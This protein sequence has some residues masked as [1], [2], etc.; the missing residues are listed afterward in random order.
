MGVDRA[1]QQ[2]VVLMS[3]ERITILETRMDSATATI[4]QQSL[5]I[6][7]LTNRIMM[8]EAESV[9]DD[10]VHKLARNIGDGFNNIARLLEV[11]E[12]ELYDSKWKRRENVS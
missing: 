3:D 2:G 6:A 8:L 12:S 10:E 9:H 11:T 5:I 4:A 7:E 1:F